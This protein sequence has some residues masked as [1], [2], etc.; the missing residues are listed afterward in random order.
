M[1]NKNHLEGLIFKLNRP[2]I[3]RSMIK[4]TKRNQ[5][6]FLYTKVKIYVSQDSCCF[7]LLMKFMS[8][9][10]HEVP[11]V[12]FKLTSCF[13]TILWVSNSKYSI[14]S[15]IAIQFVFP[16]FLTITQMTSNTIRSPAQ[17]NLFTD[18]ELQLDEASYSNTPSRVQ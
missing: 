4:N 13:H 9:I 3:S 5:H 2:D 11:L 18:G 7:L 10:R 6:H 17:T 16:L 1:T 8:V 15:I 12:Y 14:H